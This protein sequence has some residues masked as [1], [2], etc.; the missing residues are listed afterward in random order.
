MLGILLPRKLVND[1]PEAVHILKSNVDRLCS[2]FDLHATLMH[3]VFNKSVNQSTR[4][5]SLLTPLP[6]H[7]TCSEAGVARHW[8]ACAHLVTLTPNVAGDW[9]N[10]VLQAAETALKT[11]NAATRVLYTR[12]GM[13]L[14]DMCEHLKLDE[15]GA[16]HLLDCLQSNA[17][18]WSLHARMKAS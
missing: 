5:Q 12:E 3:L 14:V 18:G 1:W 16:P 7:R 9:S 4:G 6:W 2:P 11:I 15:V 17:P 8:C 13:R 10:E